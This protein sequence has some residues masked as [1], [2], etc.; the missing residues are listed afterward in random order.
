MTY[1]TPIVVDH[2]TLA[3]LTAATTNGDNTD[4]TFPTGTPISVILQNLS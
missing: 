1:E 3:Q 2:G 4:A